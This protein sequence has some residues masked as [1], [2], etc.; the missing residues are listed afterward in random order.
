M[1]KRLPYE[2]TRIEV[3][4]PT[5][6]ALKVELFLDRDMSSG[7]IAY[8]AWSKLAERLFNEFLN[9]KARVK[10]EGVQA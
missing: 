2:M 5:E 8:G 10:P 4:V 3:R 9:Q 7:K 1:P 6:L